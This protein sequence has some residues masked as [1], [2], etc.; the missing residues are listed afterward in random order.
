MI[1]AA[2]DAAVRYEGMFLTPRR[3]A[4]LLAEPQFNVYDNPEAFL[5][6]AEEERDQYRT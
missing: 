6:C 5:S 3:A 1:K 4:A 2:R